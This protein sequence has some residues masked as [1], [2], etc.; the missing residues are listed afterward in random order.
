MLSIDSQSKGPY[1]SVIVKT[2]A[3]FRCE[4][5]LGDL[6]LFEHL[7]GEVLQPADVDG[8]L[9]RGV[10]VAAAD[11]EVGGG[12]DHAAGEA[13]GVVAEDGLGGAV[14]VLVG[15][16]GDEGL[17][18]QLGGAGLLARRVRTLQTSAMFISLIIEH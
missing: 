15:D 11:A 6:H 14:V 18:V 9:L 7:H 5:Y 1:Y 10:E 17:D 3:K 4:L 2:S 13:Q 16:G 12:A 8:P